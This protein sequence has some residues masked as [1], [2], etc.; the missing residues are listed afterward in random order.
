MPT[1]DSSR[2]TGLLLARILWA[3]LFA[4]C[5]L[6]W[7]PIVFDTRQ[8]LGSDDQYWSVIP[9]L[10]AMGI[11]FLAPFLVLLRGHLAW[12][13]TAIFSIA[14]AMGAQISFSLREWA[15]LPYHVADSGFAH[16]LS[17]LPITAFIFAL[18]AVVAVAIFQ[19]GCFFRNL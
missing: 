14:L 8:K 17:N 15:L 7:S 6:L 1:S 13:P 19:V 9:G 5:A 10:G 2:R 3:I 4:F 18:G 16:A 11:T 12:L